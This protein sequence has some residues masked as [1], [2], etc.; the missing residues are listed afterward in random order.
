MKMNYVNIESSFQSV[1]LCKE[2]YLKS[3][4][5]RKEKLRKMEEEKTLRYITIF[6]PRS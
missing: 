1:K 3:N 6:C 5:K 2:Q 4:T